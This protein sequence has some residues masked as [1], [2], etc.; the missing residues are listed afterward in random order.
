MNYKTVILD[1]A[2]TTIDF[3]CFAPVAA[4]KKAFERAGLRPTIEETRAPMGMKKWDHIKKMLRGERLAAEFAEKYGRASDENDIQRIY[5]AFETELF[6][7]L[8]NFTE[9]LPGVCET[10]SLLR[11]KGIKIGSTTGYTAEMMEIVA[12]KAKEYGYAPDCVV[13]PDDVCGM[14]RPYPYMIWKNLRKLE[15]KNVLDVV[16]VGDTAADIREGK[17]AGCI[18]VGVVKG[19]SMLGWTLTEWERADKATKTEA[20]AKARRAF[21]DAGADVVLNDITELAAFLEG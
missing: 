15:V 17:N 19:S 13:T 21:L 9:P 11:E 4:F 3:G 16:K 18:S 12:A 14:G 7:V 6:A 20:C 1:W 5:D 2:G 8:E 10:V